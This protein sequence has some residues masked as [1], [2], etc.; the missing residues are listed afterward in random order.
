M[1]RYT[2]VG[3]V[4]AVVYLLVADMTFRTGLLPVRPLFDGPASHGGGQ[5]YNWVSPPPG[6]QDGGTPQPS[7][8]LVPFGRE[9]LASDS[10]E[11]PDGQAK[12]VIPEGAVEEAEGQTGVEFSIAPVDASKVGDPPEG[13]NFNGNGYRVGA[14]YV[15][16]R[17]PA[18]FAAGDTCPD[19]ST[20]KVQTCVTLVLRYAYEMSGVEMYRRSGPD[21]VP[22]VATD[23]PVTSEVYAEIPDPNGTF[24]VTGVGDLPIIGAPSRVSDFIAI[25]LGLLAVVMGVATVRYRKERKRK[26]LVARARGKKMKKPA[27]KPKG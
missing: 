3:L 12:L 7:S 5:P 25:G 15:P 20:R 23:S 10:L 24:A 18:R 1:K 4:V 19:P 9:G 17:S 2:I 22:V 13:T 14:V 27:G 21:W 26:E 11:T 8:K 6:E 16:S